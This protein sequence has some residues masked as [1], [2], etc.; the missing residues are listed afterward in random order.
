LPP[1]GS[2]RKLASVSR[3]IIVSNRLPVTLA[4]SDGA[5]TVTPSAGGLATG[6]RGPFERSGGLWIGWPGELPRLDQAARAEVSR[7]LA[8]LR[9]VPIELGPDELRRYYDG[10]AN[11]VLWPVFHYQLD[12]IPLHSAD[13]EVYQKVNARFADAV[14][15]HYRPGDVIWV[16]DYHLLLLPGLLRERLPDARIGFFLHI[17]FPASEVFRM[18]PWRGQ[19]L[20]GVLGADLIGFHTPSYARN[21]ASS[22]VRVLGLEPRLDEVAASGRRVRVGAFPMGVDVECF[23]GPVGAATEGFERRPDEHLLLAVDRLDYTKGIRRR[24]LAVERVLH[25]RP[26][27]RGKLRLIQIAVPSRE[28][29]DAYRAFRRR[30]EELVGAING[31]CSTLGGAP[32]HYLYRGFPQDQLVALYRAASAMLVTPLRDGMNLIAKEYCAA[33]FDEDGVLILSEFAGAW[34]ELKRALTINPH[35]IDGLKDAMLQALAMP[36]AERRARMRTLRKRV[37]EYDVQKWSGAFLSVL[38]AQRES[39]RG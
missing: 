26:E 11:G 30:V 29:V 15:A 8:A 9:T 35:D 27:L 28:K 38:S 13:W 3:L 16:H 1:R 14:V 20:S 6:L 21:F 25:R 39:A 5:V 22:L 18:L 4:S 37:L 24:M 17:P 19:L 36:Q 7:Q 23:A 33:R 2:A 32:I 34:D 12:A 10:F 31:R